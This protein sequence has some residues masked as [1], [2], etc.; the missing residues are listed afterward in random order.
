MAAFT[1]EY[2]VPGL[3]KV[4]AQVAGEECERLDR[5]AA[6]L[7]PQTL[8]DASRDVA[9]PLHDEFEWNDEVAAEKYRLR[10]ARS[11]IQNIVCATIHDEEVIEERAF[12]S[13]RPNPVSAYVSLQRALSNDEW[14]EHLLKTAKDEL[15]VFRAKYGRISQLASVIEAIDAL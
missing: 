6:G 1:Y 15:Q 2:R 4:P 12:V 13:V 11:I 14:K 5:S 3:Q 7:S 8:L 9:A 10:Q